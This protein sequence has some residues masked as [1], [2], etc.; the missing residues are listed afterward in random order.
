MG[1]HM[2]QLLEREGSARP[3]RLSLDE[4]TRAANL[5]RV[6]EESLA[7]FGRDRYDEAAQ[8][9]SELIGPRRELAAS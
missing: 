8:E 9:L 5:L 4:K 3:V 2:R 7:G 6:M 1:H